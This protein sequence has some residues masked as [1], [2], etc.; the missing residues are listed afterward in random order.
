MVGKALFLVELVEMRVRYMGLKEVLRSV[1]PWY[2]AA[3]AGVVAVVVGVGTAG[4]VGDS[5]GEVIEWVGSLSVVLAVLVGSGILVLVLG[6]AVVV[7]YEIEEIYE[8][9]AGTVSEAGRAGLLV[10]RFRDWLLEDWD[11]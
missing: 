3:S 10:H 6:M 8:V 9:W 4:V 1:I 5:L 7:V 2:M 11:N